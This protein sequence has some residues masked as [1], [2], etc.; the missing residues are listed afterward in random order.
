MVLWTH[1]APEAWQRAGT[2]A[3]AGPRRAGG[4][5]LW[6]WVPAEAAAAGSG[7]RRERAGGRPRCMGAGADRHG[8]RAVQVDQ[9]PE[10]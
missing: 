5:P 3:G 9:L 2:A 1:S 7:E 8:G 4:A 6:P 10:R